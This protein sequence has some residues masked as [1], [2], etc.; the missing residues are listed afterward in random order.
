[1]YKF[2]QA[3][4]KTAGMNLL[5]SNDTVLDESVPAEKRQMY[6]REKN[7]VAMANFTMAITTDG[8]MAVICMVQTKEWPGGLPRKVVEALHA[9]YM[10]KDL[11]SKVELRKALAEVKMQGVENPS[12]IFE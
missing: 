6:A 9:K 1:M 4:K 12:K 7:N 10:P 11:I 3:C 5:T 2:A 8:Y